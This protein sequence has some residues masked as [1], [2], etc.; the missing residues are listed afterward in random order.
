MAGAVEIERKFLVVSD[1]WRRGAEGVPFRQGYLSTDPDRTVRV[2]LEGD[3]GRL[4]IKGRRRG[5]EAPEFE[6][7]IPAADVTRLL[8]LC[9]APP[10]EKTRYRVPHGG[11][12]WEVDEFQGANAG[13]VVAEIE[14]ERAD[15]PIDAPPW[16]GEEVTGDP[17]YSNARLSER[18]FSTWSR[19][20]PTANR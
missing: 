14:V 3:Q 16:V 5:A 6:Y 4:T 17:R 19:S 13:L 2:R 9:T 10:I 7:E 18:P 12:V 15:Q 1:A 8:D 20:R 11:L